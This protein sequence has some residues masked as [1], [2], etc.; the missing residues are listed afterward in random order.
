MDAGGFDT[1]SRSLDAR[2]RRGA[3]GPSASLARLVSS[4]A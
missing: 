3:F 1:L 4:T 2:S